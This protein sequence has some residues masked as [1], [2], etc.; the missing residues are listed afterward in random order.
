MSWTQRLEINKLQQKIPQP[1]TNHWSEQ[2]KFRMVAQ[3]CSWN[4]AANVFFPHKSLATHPKLLSKLLKLP[5]LNTSW[6][7]EILHF[8]LHL[9]KTSA[10]TNFGWFASNSHCKTSLRLHSRVLSFIYLFSTCAKMDGTEG[11]WSSSESSESDSA[12]VQQHS[13]FG[14]F[15]AKKHVQQS[16]KINHPNKRMRLTFVH[17][18]FYKKPSIPP[19]FYHYLPLSQILGYLTLKP[20]KAVFWRSWSNFASAW[21]W[22]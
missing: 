9:R 10:K 11:A 6:L 19:F 17:L 13:S 1:L 21:R 20:P 18:P 14:R 22:S 7:P 15:S 5:V 12:S 16:N 2:A 3:P 8:T 4:K